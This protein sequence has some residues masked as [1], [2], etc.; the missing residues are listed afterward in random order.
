M[1]FNNI[2]QASMIL[3][4]LCKAGNGSIPTSHYSWDDPPETS[5]FGLIPK[6]FGRCRD[7]SSQGSSSDSDG[8]EEKIA[9]YFSG[10]KG[11]V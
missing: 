4:H 2:F 7:S 1:V 5:T 11:K 8:E 9:R 3:K 6:C 10:R